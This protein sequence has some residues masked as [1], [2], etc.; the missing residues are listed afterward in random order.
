[1][2][3]IKFTEGGEMPTTTPIN[4]FESPAFLFFI[5]SAIIIVLIIYG[6]FA[7]M[8]IRQVDLMSKTLITTASKILSMISIIHAGFAIGLI[9][10]AWAIL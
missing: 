6:I 8:I 4:L 3:H 10:L 5:K 9:F 7:L 1:M 2:R